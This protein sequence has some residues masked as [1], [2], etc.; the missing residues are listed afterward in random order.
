MIRHVGKH[1][2]AAFTEGDLVA[3][4]ANGDP[5]NNT[6]RQRISMA[7]T[8]FAWCVRE[9]ICGV[10]PADDLR[11][12]QKSYPATY[13]K[14][15]DTHP[16]RW[17]D[18]TEAFGALIGA[19]QDG[20]E[21]GL[22]DEIVIRLGLAG[23][24]AG[25]ILHLTWGD[26]SPSEIRW[27]GKGRKPRRIVPGVKLLAALDAHRSRLTQATGTFPAK[28]QQLVCKRTQGGNWKVHGSE[29]T[30]L[31]WTVPATNVSTIWRIVTQRASQAG[32]G[33]VAPHDLRRSAAGILHRS[34][35]SDG[36]HRFDL[37]DIQKVLGHS[38][39]ATTMRSY[40]DPMDTEVTDRAAQVLD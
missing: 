22:Q 10:D 9:G 29:R 26:I 38:D 5:A 32:L 12:M 23:M 17:L 39:P 30:E 27:T 19:C 20:T 15:Q 35:A 4:I 7:R 18:S 13:G 2:F 28:S 3:W 36:G 8:F 33:H 16:A 11:R 6:A 1:D 14:V 21:V 24:R 37:L 40:L 34:K 31:R 25:E